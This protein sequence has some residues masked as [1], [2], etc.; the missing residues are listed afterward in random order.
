MRSNDRVTDTTAEGYWRFNN[1]DAMNRR[2]SLLCLICRE[3]E[4]QRILG[5]E[6]WQCTICM[7]EH[8]GLK[9]CHICKGV[10]RTG[11]VWD[12][13]IPQEMNTKILTEC[14][15]PIYW[16][17]RFANI[18]PMDEESIEGNL[19]RDG[20]YVLQ[21]TR[22]WM[23]TIESDNLA[24]EDL[25]ELMHFFDV[26]ESIWLIFTYELGPAD[27][28]EVIDHLN[29]MPETLATRMIQHNY[30]MTIE[31]YFTSREAMIHWSRSR[32]HHQ[33]KQ[34]LVNMATVSQQCHKA[35]ITSLA[36]HTNEAQPY[37]Q[38]CDPQLRIEDI[39][40]PEGSLDRR[41]KQ[42]G[43]KNELSNMLLTCIQVTKYWSEH[44]QHIAKCLHM[45]EPNDATVP[46]KRSV[47]YMKLAMRNSNKS[48]KKKQIWQLKSHQHIRTM[49]CTNTI[50]K[51]Q[52][53]ET[54]RCTKMH[55][56]V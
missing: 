23:C 17:N 56:W 26:I 37:F 12:Q 31:L 10:F 52:T 43:E 2:H 47:H 50:D 1:C 35:L 7:T 39:M 36:A 8:N 44:M 6:S 54:C 5:N 46:E 51:A 55:Q 21:S 16:R 20:I 22:D 33:H 18:A 11:T 38:T 49:E 32:M 25:Q 19:D 28:D 41:L 40:I 45:S 9:V 34:I 30:T 14:V 13:R 3:E 48:H 29:T 27:P 42:Q 15:D 24:F 4:A 53:E